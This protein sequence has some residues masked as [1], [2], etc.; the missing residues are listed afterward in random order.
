MS[1]F[2]ADGRRGVALLLAL[3]VLVL[4]SF[5]GLETSVFSRAD[6]GSA[7]YLKERTQTYYLARGG[8]ER[9]LGLLA[10]YNLRYP[11]NPNL[12]RRMGG[13]TASG[14]QP[15]LLTWLEDRGIDRV[16]LGEGRYTLRFEDL[17]GRV[18]VNRTDQQLL[19]NLAQLTGV[20]RA[21]AQA[22]A[23]AILD[24]IDADDLH[25][26][27]GAERRW[28]ER[29]GL[30]P[31]RNAPALTISELLLVNGVTDEILYGGGRYKGLARFLTTQ[32]TGKINANTAPPE[33][34]SAIPGMD[35][36]TVT[37]IVRERER[38]HLRSLN[39]V[40][41]DGAE[42]RLAASPVLGVLS[43]ETSD[44]AV[45]GLGELAGSSTRTRIRAT[46]GLLASG[47]ILRTWQDDGLAGLPL[48]PDTPLTLP[49]GA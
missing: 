39:E 3:W 12:A 41:G 20:E 45:E 5:V 14:P 46:V 4:L 48:A 30:P 22:V 42:E 31:P 2:A 10:E 19:A 44:L 35:R 25:R 18:N 1:V 47:V 26:G 34:L 40:L 17:S 21:R 8:V 27:R 38:R 36:S 9:G 37:R 43:F 28:Y 7:R 13:E 11:T 16:P 6:L 32:G 23:D 15:P 33:V 24:W 29:R 49:G